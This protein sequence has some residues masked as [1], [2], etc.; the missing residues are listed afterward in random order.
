VTRAHRW[1]RQLI[2][3]EV[4]SVTRI[5]AAEGLD[6][7]D[8]GR[9]LQLAFLAPGI[10]EAILTGRQPVELTHRSLSRLADLPLA[11]AEQRKVLGFTD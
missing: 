2:A 6:R 1:A 5:A 10:V 4:A 8:V 11:W 9:S 7:S 3:G